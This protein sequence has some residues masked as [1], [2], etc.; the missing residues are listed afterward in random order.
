MRLKKVQCMGRVGVFLV[1]RAV[2]LAVQV[3][4]SRLVAVVKFGSGAARHE[5]RPDHAVTNQLPVQGI[6]IYPDIP[7]AGLIQGYD[8]FFSGGGR[9][10]YPFQD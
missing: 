7:A 10:L 8:P 6:G 4:A 9:G 1:A 5:R 2:I 3:A